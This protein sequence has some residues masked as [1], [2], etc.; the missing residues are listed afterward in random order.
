M[1][2]FVP[3]HC[4]GLILWL[5]L[6]VFLPVNYSVCQSV[7][8]FLP[9]FLHCISSIHVHIHIV[10][11][12]LGKLLSLAVNSSMLLL[13]VDP[14]GNIMNN[15]QSR[16]RV[17]GGAGWLDGGPGGGGFQDQDREMEGG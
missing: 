7:T 3:V 10:Q 14:K 15:E 2:Q 8:L 17:G 1:T 13:A 9:P 12:P 4:S 6:L 11:V 5:L 16:V